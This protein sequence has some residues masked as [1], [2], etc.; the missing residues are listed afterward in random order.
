MPGSR[1][2]EG[3]ITIEALQLSF[4]AKVADALIVMPNQVPSNPGGQ[5]TIEA[6]QVQFT[7]KVFDAPTVIPNQVPI[8]QRG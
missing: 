6:L 2:L 8:N 1:L 5:T 7:V 3:Q 4:T